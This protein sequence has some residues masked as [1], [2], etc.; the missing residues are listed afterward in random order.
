MFDILTFFD[1]MIKIKNIWHNKMFPIDGNGQSS[2]SLIVVSL[3][4][5]EL[6]VISRCFF[7][8]VRISPFYSVSYGKK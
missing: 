8:D 5:K 7:K 2:F 6:I 3:I 1:Q 4:P